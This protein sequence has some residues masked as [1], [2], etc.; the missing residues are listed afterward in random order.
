[1]LLIVSFW[2]IDSVFIPRISLFFELG[3]FH[4]YLR[5]FH[6]RLQTPTLEVYAVQLQPMYD[7]EFFGEANPLKPEEAR[8]W[9]LGAAHAMR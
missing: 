2:Y 6:G 4:L 8:I 5:P 9:N 7:Y 3:N 1:M